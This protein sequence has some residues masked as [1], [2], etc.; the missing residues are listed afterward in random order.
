MVLRAWDKPWVKKWIETYSAM[1]KVEVT[2]FFQ[3]GTVGSLQF[4]KDHLDPSIRTDI[5]A[6][7]SLYALNRE[8][9]YFLLGLGLSKI[10]LSLEDDK[11]NLESQIRALPENFPLQVILYRD[12]PLFI[13]ESCSLTALHGGCPTAKVCGYRTL[14]IQNQK[15]ETFFVAHEAC[16]SIVYGEKAYAVG[17][18]KKRLETWGVRDFRIDLITRN[19][20]AEEVAQIVKTLLAEKN[21][22]LSHTANFHRTLL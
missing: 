4:L 2:H 20:N 10:C 7:F 8:A 19:Y 5:S 11:E 16:K 9:S 15:G 17:S 12:T 13:A 18:E 3:V 14:E 1:E 21:P 6:D 22:L